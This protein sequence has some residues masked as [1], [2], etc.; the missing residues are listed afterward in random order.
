MIHEPKINRGSLNR[1]WFARFGMWSALALLLLSLYGKWLIAAT[2][3]PLQPAWYLFG[4][5][6]L[7]T[8]FLNV[9]L[10]SQVWFFSLCSAG[11]IVCGLL[12]FWGGR[13]ARAVS[14]SILALV[15][16]APFA[17]AQIYGQYSLRTVEA[18]RGYVLDWLTQP[19]GNFASAFRSAQR[20]HDVTG[21]KYRLHGWTTDHRLY[22]GSSCVN[23]LWMYDPQKSELPG[24]VNRLPSDFEPA[25][26]LKSYWSHPMGQSG[27]LV[28]RIVEESKSTDG[29]YK[30]FVV[31]DSFYGPYDVLVMRQIAPD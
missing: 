10:F 12:W 8:D 18:S 4:P 6:I 11:L 1:N 5:F 17:L 20:E 2:P 13:R 14:A 30:A 28:T 15:L 21:C 7:L 27:L 16:V 25:S 23:D 22:F 26:S 24:R 3:E 19:E 31:Q 29:R 9:V